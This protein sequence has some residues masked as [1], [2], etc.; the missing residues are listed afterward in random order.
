MLSATRALR[1][2]LIKKPRVRS[3]H[4]PFAAL[5]SS[6]SPL[7]KPPAADPASVYEK[8]HEPSADPHVSHTGA[9]TYVVSQ[10]DPAD[11]PYAVPSGAYPSSAPYQNPA[12]VEE[13]G[14]TAHSSTSASAAQPA[15]TNRVPR[16]DEGVG[17]SAA[18]RHREAPGGMGRR[19]GSNTGLN[20]M[21]AETTKP[22]P[23]GELAERNPPPLQAKA[24]HFS[25]KG[26]DD[27]WKERK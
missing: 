11:T 15:T 8:Q 9:R 17:E 4:S 14:E 19:G 18:V 20:L 10:P 12:A 3:F 7:T 21:D 1:S 16:N 6:S 22:G 24:E 23:D 27:A 26:V 25:K 5:S 2:T 13:P